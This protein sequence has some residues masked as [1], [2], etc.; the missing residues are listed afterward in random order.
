MPDVF[1]R[2]QK[3]KKKE[4][5]GR[6]VRL[7]VLIIMQKMVAMRREI[8][9]LSRPDDFRASSNSFSLLVAIAASSVFLCKTCI[10]MQNFDI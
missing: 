10:K 2:K 5:E 6:A 7:G 4:K 8:P 1:G 9:E 3:K